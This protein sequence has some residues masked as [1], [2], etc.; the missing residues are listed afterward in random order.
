MFDINVKKNGSDVKFKELKRHQEPVVFKYRV[1]TVIYF[2]FGVIYIMI[3][4]YQAR[5]QK[6]F[7]AREIFR[8]LDTLINI[9]LKAEK[10]SIT[11]KNF[12]QEDFFSQIL[13]KLHFE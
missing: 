11:E 4:I 5:N 1:L 2:F 9:S 7:R 13:L 10:K 12:S 3:S 8:N 6:F